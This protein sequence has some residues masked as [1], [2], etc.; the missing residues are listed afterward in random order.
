MLCLPNGSHLGVTTLARGEHGIRFA[1]D[2]FSREN[3]EVV[4][5]GD[6]LIGGEKRG[7][8]SAFVSAERPCVPG[9]YAADLF[10]AR[11]REECRVSSVWF[12][13]RATRVA[14]VRRAPDRACLVRKERTIDKTR[15]WTR[16]GLKRGTG[17]NCCPKSCWSGRFRS[18]E[19]ARRN[20]HAISRGLHSGERFVPAGSHEGEWNLGYA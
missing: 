13:L 11:K 16:C 1:A 7:Q 5:D 14:S 4:V 12:L 19:A 2:D 8:L 15:P 3:P 6:V 10:A 18:A 20:G 17:M 9:V